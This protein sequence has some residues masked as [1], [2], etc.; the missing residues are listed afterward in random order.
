SKCMSALAMQAISLNDSDPKRSSVKH[1]R[2]STHQSAYYFAQNRRGEQQDDQAGDK[3][4]PSIR[5]PPHPQLRDR[6]PHSDGSDRGAECE[7]EQCRPGLCTQREPDH[8]EP[9]GGE[10]ET[11]QGEQRPSGDSTESLAVPERER[12]RG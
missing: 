9:G 12:T 3:F 11:Y 5:A 7:D 8:G 1:D 10:P 4:D 6:S 2:R